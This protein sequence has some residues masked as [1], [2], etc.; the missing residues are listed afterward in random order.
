M[1]DCDTLGRGRSN[2]G[3]HRL[4]RSQREALEPGDRSVTA[5][6]SRF[7]RRAQCHELQPRRHAPCL[8]GDRRGHPCLGADVL[9]GRACQGQHERAVAWTRISPGAIVFIWPDRSASFW[10]AVAKRSGDTASASRTGTRPSKPCESGV[11]GACRCAPNY[12]A[13]AVQKLA[14]L[15]KLSIREGSPA[16]HQTTRPESRHDAT[17]NRLR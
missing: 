5:R 15:T 11:G 12:S 13:T 8:L 16:G 1:R 14:P 10:T 3:R 7:S 4:R 9:E 6:V 17:L 2:P